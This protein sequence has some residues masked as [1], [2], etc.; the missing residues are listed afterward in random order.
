MK[1]EQKSNCVIRLDPA[2]HRQA[3][4]LAATEGLTLT[5]LVGLALEKELRRRQ[6]NEKNRAARAE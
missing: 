2:T 3:K 6:R 4:I 5:A 1:I